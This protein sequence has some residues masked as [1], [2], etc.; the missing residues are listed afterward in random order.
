MLDNYQADGRIKLSFEAH[1]I[2]RA[3]ASGPA[4]VLED[5]EFLEDDLYML[6]E[7]ALSE[8]N[9]ADYKVNSYG[10]SQH[11]HPEH[12]ASLALKGN[13]ED[14]VI[15]LEVASRGDFQWSDAG[16][17][18]FVIHKSDLIKRDF[19]NVFCTMYSS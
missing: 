11:Q 9:E 5:S 17:L 2:Y 14:W 3:E 1:S 13:P 19:S 4:A 16:E 8:K 12:E 15:L 6:F 7:E 18:F 10:F